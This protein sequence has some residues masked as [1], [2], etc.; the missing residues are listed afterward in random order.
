[1]EC[2]EKYP[3][4]P[5][6]LRFLSRINISC[7]NATNGLVDNRG[8][9]LLSRWQRDYTLKTVLQ[10]LRRLMTMKDNLKLSQPPEGAMF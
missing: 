5:P 3:D 9:P 2:G 7:A 1:M 6:S 10:E 4:D 8:V